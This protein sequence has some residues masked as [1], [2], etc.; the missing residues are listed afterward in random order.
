MM[1][2]E[3][4]AHRKERRVLAVAQQH[5]R[6][7]HPTCRLASGARNA[8]QPRDL[9]LAHRQLDHSPPSCHNATLRSINHSQESI[10]THPFHT[11]GF[12]ESLVYLA[13]RSNLGVMS[14]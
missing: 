9:L 13:D 11:A 14:S 7:L 10:K 4:S 3:P 8:C 5:L 12:M 1:Y 2:A 6:T